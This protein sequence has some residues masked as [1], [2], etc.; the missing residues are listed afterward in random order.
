MDIS[1]PF[2]GKKQ[3]SEV[4]VSSEQPIFCQYCGARFSVPQEPL[5]GMVDTEDADADDKKV[6]KKITES[7]L[8]EPERVDKPAREP[9]ASRTVGTYG[10]TAHEIVDATEEIVPL[11]RELRGSRIAPRGDTGEKDKRDMVVVTGKTLKTSKT[12][13]EDGYA[14]K[15][16]K[17]PVVGM[18]EEL[19]FTPPKSRIEELHQDNLLGESS[20]EP[21]KEPNVELDFEDLT[22][23]DR[24]KGASSREAPSFLDIDS[25][26]AE[27]SDAFALGTA[28]GKGIEAS[29]EAEKNRGSKPSGLGLPDEWLSV[30]V[31]E[32]SGAREPEA[33]MAS[34]EIP[35]SLDI[36]SVPEIAVGVGEVPKPVT[37]AIEGP[38]V[39]VTS[40]TIKPKVRKVSSASPIKISLLALFILVGVGV[41]L[42]QTDYGY[43]GVNLMFPPQG[44][45]T[46]GLRVAVPKTESSGILRDTCEAFIY[47]IQR[48][49]KRLGEE[50][51]DMQAKQGLCEVLARFKE[52]YPTTFFATEKYS[53]RLEQL[54]RDT[55]LPAHLKAL[56]QAIQLMSSGSLEEAKAV[57]HGVRVGQGD[58]PDVL[59]LLGKVALAQKDLDEAQKFFESALLKNPD[60]LA[61]RYFLVKTYFEKGDLK[62]AKAMVQ[63]LLNREPEHHGA[64]TL[65][66]MI[67]L[68]EK[69]VETAKKESSFVIEKADRTLWIDEVFEAHKTLANAFRMA[70]DDEGYIHELKAALSLKPADEDAAASAAE[71]LL[72]MRKPEEA[73]SVLEPCWNKKCEGARFLKV[74]LRASLFA[75]DKKRAEDALNIGTERYPKDAEFYCIYGRYLL[76][77]NMVKAASTYLRKAVEADESYADGYIFLSDALRRE[78]KLSEARDILKEGLQKVQ[79]KVKL[80]LALAEVYR[81]MR[82]YQGAEEALR[83]IL[84]KDP[85]NVQVSEMLGQVLLSASRPEES[86]V[87]LGALFARKVLSKEGTLSLAQAYLLSGKPQKAMEALATVYDET[88]F[89]PKIACEY[90]KVLLEAGAFTEAQKVLKRVLEQMPG[91]ALAYY[92]TGVLL[93]KKHDLKKAAEALTKAVQIE[94]NDTRFRFE[95]ARV[96]VDLG[97]DDNVREALAHLDKV[98]QTYQTGQASVETRNPD[99][100]VLRGQIL[101]AKQRYAQALKDFEQALAMQP[102]RLDILVG[103]GRSLFEMAR[104]D[105]AVPYFQQVVTREPMH[106]DANYYLGRISLRNGQIEKAKIY[107]EH[108]IQRDVKKFPEAYRLLGLIYRDQNLLPLARKYLA[109]YLELAPKNTREAEEVQNILHRMR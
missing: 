68:N 37:P 74:F 34:S 29:E 47:E 46:A 55:E 42:G 86:S 87:I 108:A 77:N 101:F 64:R 20:F 54:L 67:A 94:P 78:A 61:L 107:L 39:P 25:I 31:V 70:G 35:L 4:Q 106:P 19:D 89:D 49:E 93:R 9:Q 103:C 57:L 104:Y 100:F 62:S 1:C 44:G 53:L 109:R 5:V 45:G 16:G 59:Y 17:P 99:V 15:V 88:N 75:M 76:D 36:P 66:A 48:L 82:D 91:Y 79:E 38:K 41:I 11:G 43:F 96:L 56:I 22:Q 13:E 81:E 95:L 28:T 84:S 33:S 32:E 52:R 58:R 18:L 6:T 71:A 2:C 65:M 30:P 3:T 92:Y 50:P 27:D 51:K 80:L 23:I 97:G 83:E 12:L 90:A 60:H 40:H 14:P 85:N 102:S 69:D 10:L 105:E 98:V 72:A 21:V 7:W 8:K 73:L 63:D 24:S 26:L